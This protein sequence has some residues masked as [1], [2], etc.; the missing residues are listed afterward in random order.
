MKKNLKWKFKMQFKLRQE[1]I[2]KNQELEL[3]TDQRIE[4]AIERSSLK[5]IASDFQF[6]LENYA[7]QF[8]F[9]C[10]KIEIFIQYR[11]ICYYNRT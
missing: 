10:Q 6:T 8:Q 2:L 5:L 3:Y 1:D 4:N 11:K 9:L 7:F